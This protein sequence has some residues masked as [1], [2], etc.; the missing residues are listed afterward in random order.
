MDKPAC[1]FTGHRQISY[2]ELDRLEID[3]P[4]EIRSLYD[5][6]YTVFYAGGALGFDTLAALAVLNLKQ[7]YDDVELRLLLPGKGQ[8]NRWNLRQKRIYREI[9]EQADSVEY[10]CDELTPAAMHIRNRELVNRSQKCVSYHINDSSGTAYTV[11]YAKEKGIEV[12]NLT[13]E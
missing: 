12:K 1:C 4:A 13:R 8:E 3:L 9:L 6:G 2:D 11:N 7:S 10:L 5:E